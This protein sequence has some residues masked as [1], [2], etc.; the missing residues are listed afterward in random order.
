MI[1][2]ILSIHIIVVSCNPTCL[3][4]SSWWWSNRLITTGVN[5]HDINLWIVNDV[6]VIV[7]NS[8]IID[9]LLIV[10]V[11]VYECIG[12]CYQWY[13][14]V[15]VVVQNVCCAWLYIVYHAFSVYVDILLSICLI[16]IVILM[17]CTWWWWIRLG[18]VG[19]RILIRLKRLLFREIIILKRLLSS[20][21][22]EV[23]LWGIMHHLFV[24]SHNISFVRGCFLSYIWYCPL[25]Y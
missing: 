10:A 8:W 9:I 14:L 22:S 18:I 11:N 15:Y 6:I 7:Y 2:I 12:I 19:I 23:A 4:N 20:L 3:W 21:L 16:V 24:F 1:L 5:L 17:S 13:I 25:E